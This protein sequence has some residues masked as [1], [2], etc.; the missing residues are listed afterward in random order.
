MNDEIAIRTLHFDYH[1]NPHRHHRQH[2]RRRRRRRRL[3]RHS[4][5]HHPIQQNLRIHILLC[6]SVFFSFVLKIV[7]VENAEK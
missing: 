6:G 1:S 7:D 5:Y 2:Y 3:L 4:H